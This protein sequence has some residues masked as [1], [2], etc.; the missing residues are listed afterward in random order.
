VLHRIRPELEQHMGLVFEELV[1]QL[2]ASRAILLP[3]KP[4]YVGQW[5]K[6]GAQID[7]VALDQHN[8][9]F[10]EVKWGRATS[11]DLTKL[12]ENSQRV[13]VGGRRRHY[14][15]VAREGSGVDWLIDFEELDKLTK[16][17]N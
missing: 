16:P 4:T 15:V 5:W 8:A 6:G 13:D 17:N 1:R 12:I 7:V 9:L 10:A 11:Q 3:F 14:L 2:I